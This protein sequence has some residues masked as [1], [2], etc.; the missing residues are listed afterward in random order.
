MEG[1][2]RPAHRR[3]RP[4]VES[5]VGSVHLHVDVHDVGQRV[6]LAQRPALVEDR[7]RL[8][9]AAPGLRAIVHGLGAGLARVGAA[10]VAECCELAVQRHCEGLGPRRQARAVLPPRRDAAGRRLQQVVGRAREAAACA[11]GRVLKGAVNLARR[12]GAVVGEPAGGHRGFWL[13]VEH[14]PIAGLR[15]DVGLGIRASQLQA[16]VN[17]TGRA[18]TRGSQQQDDLEARGHGTPR[19]QRRIHGGL[20]E[21]RRPPG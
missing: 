10:D 6:E 15:L 21:A 13:E 5:E 9:A 20:L 11:V 8:R 16:G 12:R 17:C 7:A 4:C 3:H 14:V 18:H 1:R 19:P 2:R